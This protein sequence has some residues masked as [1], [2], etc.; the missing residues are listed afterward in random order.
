MRIES[1]RDA[2]LYWYTTMQIVMVVNTPKI[3]QPATAC[4]WTFPAIRAGTKPAE[5]SN[6]INRNATKKNRPQEL[7]DFQIP[8]DGI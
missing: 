6:Y 4:P 3:T 7:V 1:R 2:A 5:S 8:K